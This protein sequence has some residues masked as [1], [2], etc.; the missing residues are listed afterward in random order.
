VNVV[1]CDDHR[2]F[3]DALATVLTARDW[4]IVACAINPAHAVAAITEHHVD[5][6]LMDLSFPDGDSGLAGI[7]AVRQ[8]SPHTKVVV[9]TATSD[10]QLIVRAVESGAHAIAF[11]DDDIDHIIDIVERTRDG[12]I[13]L[14]VGR[15]RVVVEP[16]VPADAARRGREREREAQDLVRFLT[17]RERE[18]LERMVRGESGRD[19]ARRMNV[20]Y[21]TTRT[22]IQNILAKL[23]VHSQLE[24]IALAIQHGLGGPWADHAGGEPVAASP[25]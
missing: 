5:T 20:S 16:A 4:S 1:I 6:C 21:S 18:V 25:G 14:P 3:S 2:L 13:D 17:T 12:S 15:T 23:G 7:T 10:P 22:H 9:L 24:A 19:L 11:K 8:A